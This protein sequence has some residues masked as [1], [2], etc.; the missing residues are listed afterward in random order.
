VRVEKLDRGAAIVAIR[1]REAELAAFPVEPPATAADVESAVAHV[2]LANRE[3]DQAKEE[4]N[5]KEGALSKV[6]GSA[7]REEVGRIEEARVTA[8]AR[9][10]ELE[11]DADAWKLLR[12][13]LREVENEEGAHLG[14]ALAGPVTTRFEEL[15]AGR[16][17]GL[18]LDAT[19]K[20]ESL[21]AMT[22][23]AAG[24]EVLEALSVGTRDQLAALIRLTI[25]DQLRS[26]IVLDD[27]LVHSDPARLLW[28]RDVLQRT[29]VNA[30]VIVLT[31]RAGDYLSLSELPIDTPSYDAAAGTIRAINVALCLTPP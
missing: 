18:R 26:T 13:T 17:R 29:A 11:V 6:G 2:E 23:N 12:D 8:E 16:Y 9:E 25:A 28:F 15:T 24:D 1:S 5:L 31:C 14:R 4:L 19:L 30:Q 20:A 21:E 7:L 3:H 27:H 22:A 10:R